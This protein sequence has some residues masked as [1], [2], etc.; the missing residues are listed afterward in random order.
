MVQEPI[1]V[2]EQHSCG[3]CPRHMYGPHFVDSK[4]TQGE[5]RTEV[6]PTY[7]SHS[8][9][10]HC[11]C[12]GN[13]VGRLFTFIS[14]L[15][16]MWPAFSGK[17]TRFGPP[18]TIKAG[19]VWFVN[20]G[21]IME[22][23][24]MWLW[25]WQLRV[26]FDDVIINSLNYWTFWMAVVMLHS[27]IYLAITLASFWNDVQDSSFPKGLNLTVWLL[28]APPSDSDGIRRNGRL[29]LWSL[30]SRKQTYIFS[31]CI[32]LLFHDH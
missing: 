8:V 15:E 18:H 27:S 4:Q 6:V 5:A 32:L 12:H 10:R 24:T 17:Q 26:P 31:V 7:K 13:C 29:A 20:S 16:S 3:V 11:V 9:R 23:T 1:V 2:W 28:W 14:Q 25:C 19:N 21:L 22:I 30:S